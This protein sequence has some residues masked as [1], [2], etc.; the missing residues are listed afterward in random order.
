MKALAKRQRNVMGGDVQ[1]GGGEGG[2]EGVRSEREGEGWSD[3]GCVEATGH[4]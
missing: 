4:V 3:V 1:V 2:S